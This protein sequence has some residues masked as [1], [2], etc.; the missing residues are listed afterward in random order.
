MDEKYNFVE[1]EYK[2][3]LDALTRGGI[4]IDI[5]RKDYVILY[6][7]QTLIDK[8]GDSVGSACYEK[9]MGLTRPCEFCAMEKSIRNNTVEKT[10]LKGT[11]GRDYELVSV[12]LPNPDG[13]IDK[14][15]E[16]AIDLTKQKTIEEE[17]RYKDY[18]I[19]STASAIATYDLQG[20]I[21]FVNPTFVRMWG[22]NDSKEICG[23]NFIEFFKNDPVVIE[24]FQI[25]LKE[26][27]WFGELIANRKDGT[28]FDIQA[29]AS[30]V[31]DSNGT[32]IALMASIIDITDRKHNEELLKCSEE[33]FF[34]TFQ[35]S[36]VLMA[37]STIEEGKFID[38][39]KALLNTLGF[40]REEVIGRTSKELNLYADYAQRTILIDKLKE[41]DNVKNFELNVRTKDGRIVNGLFSSS[42]INI[43][44]KPYVLSMMTDITEL[45]KAELKL[46]ESEEQ[47]RII[48]EQSLMGIVIIQDNKIQFINRACLDIYGLTLDQV[49]IFGLNELMERIH[50]DDKEFVYDQMRKK[51]SSDP[52]PDLM[53]NYQ[54]RALNQ[55]G[56]IVWTEVYSKTITFNEKP[57]IF[58][59]LIDINEKRKTEENL[60]DSEEKYRNLFEK[61]S[62]AIILF[63]ISGNIINCNPAAEK[64]VGYS[65]ND[66]IGKNYY[67]FS[68]FTQNIE[69]GPKERFQAINKSNVEPYELEIMRKNGTKVRIKVAISYFKIGEEEYFQVIIEDITERADYEQKLKK[70]EEKYRLISENAYDLIAILDS[71]FKHIYINEGAYKRTLGYSQKD[72]LGKISWDFVHPEDV[73]SLLGS[74][75]YREMDLSEFNEFQKEQ[76]R[77][78]RKNGT[79]VWLE[80]TSK[81]FLNESGEKNV[82]LISRDITERKSSEKEIKRRNLE[83]SVLNKI[84]TLGN[85]LNNLEEFLSKAYNEVLK[86][87]N[88]DRGGVYLYDPDTKHNKLVYYTN[89]NPEFIKAVN[90]ID[91]SSKPFN[92]VFDKNVPYYI[93][94]FSEYMESSKSLGVHSAV[95]IP[96]RSKNEYVGSMNFGAPTHQ[97]LTTHELNLLVAIGKQMGILIQKFESERLLKESEEKY[98]FYFENSPIGI[99][100]FDKEGILIEANTNSFDYLTGQPI[101]M[102]IGKT[103]LEIASYFK[104]PQE[105]EQEIKR[106][107]YLRAKGEK[108]VPVEL[109]ILKHNGKISWVQWNSKTI[110]IK[111]KRYLLGALVDITKQKK[112]QRLIVEE[113]KK[114]QELI[115]MRQELVTRISHELKTPITS[116]YGASQALFEL[117]KHEMS[118]QV[119]E[120]VDIMQRG[121]KRLKDLVENLLDVSRLESR[122]FKINISTV[123]IA[124]II[125]E[126]VK[127]LDYMARTRKLSVDISNIEDI[128]LEVDKLLIG[129]VITNV[130]SNAIN[131]T[132]PGG[133]ITIRTKQLKEQVDIVISDTGVG[134]TKEE[135]SRLF[136]KFGKIERFGRGF[137]VYTEGS[138]L[139]LFIS[140]EFVKLHGGRMFVESKGRN[141]GAMFTI[142]L[143]K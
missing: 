90:Y 12:P 48:A 62:N 105:L 85:E 36:I 23:K 124:E 134:I 51:L 98:R 72:M 102:L 89:V 29:S 76:L 10:E 82:M 133:T 80:Y 83:L 57:A 97:V 107:E 84:I 16:I 116:I 141:K 95:I 92:I 100:L 111:D 119:F 25:V 19:N 50:P 117:H 43:Q 33:K 66:I 136:K 20:I 37:I 11:D 30:T 45:K 94:D 126:R 58:I 4:G 59:T 55:F 130:I 132:P 125:K 26:R 41:F 13:S 99:F 121:I 68:L 128:I 103:I 65:L 140:N 143:L 135:K 86:T 110:F 75:N 73:K 109:R 27:Y 142:Q 32:P 2:A 53:T 44:D 3:L 70:S 114:L 64:L 7:N 93:E 96:L 21:N 78:R 74:K 56:Q 118:D 61:S 14:V 1:G 122:N 67:K 88:F 54:L 79:Y 91:I 71:M 120:F 47:F 137:D 101:S 69:K 38:V 129:Q 108:E 22:Y 60:R 123:N 17:L 115:T 52:E 106:R 49:K 87:V 112:A 81:I 77:I 138:G 35:E 6:Q 63:D 127:E 9:Y 28:L 24:A 40:T 15:V 104:N 39:N 131:N 42:R 139:G 34:L 113:N 5:I 18:I 31:Y 46:K 8:F